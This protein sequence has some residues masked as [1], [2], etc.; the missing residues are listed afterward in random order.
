MTTHEQ[1]TQTALLH[2]PGEFVSEQLEHDCAR[3][4]E[5]LRKRAARAQGNVGAAAK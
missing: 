2:P 5:E 1:P 4:L 3:F